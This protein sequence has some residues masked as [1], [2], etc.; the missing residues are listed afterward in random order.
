MPRPQKFEREELLD[1]AIRVFW[2]RGYEATSVHDL[3]T[4]MRI[5]PGT[6]Y[7]LFGDKHALFIEALSRYE[8]TVGEHFVQLVG[9]DL[10]A[11][12]AFFDGSAEMLSSSQGRNGCLLTNATVECGLTDPDVA[13][14]ASRHI[15]R[16]EKA[17]EKALRN[18]QAIEEIPLSPGVNL[19][20][21]A[22][23]LSSVLQ[24]MRVLAKTG[25]GA[26]ELHEIV[27]TAFACLPCLESSPSS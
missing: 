14:C 3:V 2:S 23:H 7:H 6:L 21:A 4:A 17:F 9:E 26:E 5:H 16:M 20:A 8:Q 27:Q 19:Q 18:S 10:K 11:V 25:V 22:H 12:R 1:G 24:G 13:R 15:Q